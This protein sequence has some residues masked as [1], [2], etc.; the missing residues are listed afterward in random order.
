MIDAAGS[1]RPRAPTSISSSPMPDGVSACSGSRDTP[2]AP[3][4]ILPSEVR[5][6]FDRVRSLGT[7][8]AET[9]FGAPRL[10]VKG[11]S[12]ISHGKSSPRA[13]MNACK[14]AVRAVEARLSEHTGRRLPAG[15]ETP[16]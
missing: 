4:L 2:G 7:P 10:G 9:E 5:Q 12:I 14:V 11:V 3:W 1:S 6:A 8:L 13:I 16:A 15:V